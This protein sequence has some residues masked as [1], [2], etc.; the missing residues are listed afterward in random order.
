[1]DRVLHNFGQSIIIQTT[2]IGD[3][4]VYLTN[5]HPP[6]PSRLK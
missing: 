1:M 6:D 2:S 5:R 3:R 4:D